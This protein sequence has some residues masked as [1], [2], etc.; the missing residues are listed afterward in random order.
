MLFVHVRNLL[1]MPPL[2]SNSPK[3]ISSSSDS[4]SSFFFS[5]ARKMT[6]INFPG[7]DLEAHGVAQ[8]AI[9]QEMLKSH[10]F[11]RKMV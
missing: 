4:D 10:G 7:R 9:R 6:K 5:S 3:P 1:P 8:S 2:Y 11:M